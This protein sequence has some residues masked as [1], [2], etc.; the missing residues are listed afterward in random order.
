L[1]NRSVDAALVFVGSGSEEDDLQRYAKEHRIPDVH[2]LGFR[3]QSE[4]PKLYGLSDVFVLPSENEPWGLI[5]NEVMCA[6]LPVVATREIGAV[7]DLVQHG[8]NGLLYSTGNMDELRAHLETL[9]TDSNLRCDM[10]ER[11][12]EIIGGWNYDRCVEGLRNAL[13]EVA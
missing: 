5:I 1:R 10:G 2:F 9:V 11:S 13:A 8:E 12:H 6:G 3:N 7:P 4:L